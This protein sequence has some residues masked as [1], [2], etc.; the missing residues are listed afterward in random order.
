[1]NTFAFLCGSLI[2][3][4]WQNLST[5]PTTALGRAACCAAQSLHREL[6]TEYEVWSHQTYTKQ[7]SP[8]QTRLYQSVPQYTNTYN[9]PIEKHTKTFHPKPAKKINANRTVPRQHHQAQSQ[10]SLSQ[11]PDL[12]ALAPFLVQTADFYAIGAQH[13][14]GDAYDIEHDDDDDDGTMGYTPSSQYSPS[15]TPGRQ[16]FDI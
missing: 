6:S 12:N 11:L 3:P 15:P 14:H 4:V 10:N 2:A 5:D 13:A 1:M 8:P 16:V 7:A 9:R